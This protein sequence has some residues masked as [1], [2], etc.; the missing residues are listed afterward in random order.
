MASGHSFEFEARQNRGVGRKAEFGQILSFE[1][2]SDCLS[3]IGRQLVE[4]RGLRD[5]RQIKALSYVLT[6]APKNPHMNDVLHEH[7]V[8]EKRS[9]FN[10]LR[11]WRPQGDSNPRYRRERAMS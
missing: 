8:A 1:V 10:W 5:H 4:S 7:T 9:G 6:V 3:D 2:E 11:R